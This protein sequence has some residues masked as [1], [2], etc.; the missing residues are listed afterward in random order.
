MFSQQGEPLT[1][2]NQSF[3]HQFI[4][5]QHKLLNHI[6]SRPPAFNFKMSGVKLLIHKKSLPISIYKQGPGIITKFPSFLRN[7]MHGPDISNQLF[8][9]L[10]RFRQACHIIINH[11]LGLFISQFISRL[12]NRLSNPRLFRQQFPFFI[13]FKEDRKGQSLHSWVQRA[14]IFT[15]QS[16]QHRNHAESGYYRCTK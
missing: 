8:I 1:L 4:R 16:G 5:Q 14:Q 13:Y 3:P 6:I 2:L 9:F 15:K 10:H 11:F 12:D 7:S